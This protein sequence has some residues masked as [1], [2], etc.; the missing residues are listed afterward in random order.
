MHKYLCVLLSFFW[1]LNVGATEVSKAPPLQALHQLEWQYRVL[2]IQASDP[3]RTFELLKRFEADLL[4]RKIAWFVSHSDQISS[5]Y[6]G[7]L[8]PA[9][10]TQVEQYLA[11]ADTDA[12]VLIGYDG[13]VKS[14][15]S[16]QLREVFEQIDRMPIRRMEM[17]P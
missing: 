4:E 8:E 16:E 11:R 7:S 17:Q 12:I 9:F 10:I 14:Q 1:T 5:N 3:A 15:E 13:E 2:L 6:P